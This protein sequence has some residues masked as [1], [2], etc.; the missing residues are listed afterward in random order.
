MSRN[1]QS[2]GGDAIVRARYQLVMRG[3][4]LIVLGY[5]V[6]PMSGSIEIVLISIGWSYIFLHPVANWKL[7]NIVLAT[8]GLAVASIVVHALTPFVQL[9]KVLLPG[10][11]RFTWMTYFAVGLLAYHLLL[12]SKKRQIVV[13][14][15]G[16]I[17]AIAGIVARQLPSNMEIVDTK[18]LAYKLFIGV[19]DAIPH[20]GG[21]IDLIASNAAS[22]AVIALCVLAFKKDTWVSPLQAMGSM[23]L[24][25]YIAHVLSAGQVLNEAS[26]KQ[27]PVTLIL[28]IV[29]SLVL[30]TLWKEFR[31]RGPLESLMRKFVKTVSMSGRESGRDS[32]QPVEATQPSPQL[33]DAPLADAPS[34]DS[35]A[36]SSTTAKN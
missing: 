16:T 29:L 7:K 5:V 28:T 36:T 18:S 35:G 30:A 25:V 6:M 34:P 3:V 9:P 19:I 17:L 26:V 31:G 8:G 12:E 23:S 15:S 2:R 32:E 14:I 27:H 1:A 10:Y 22:L 20:G 33:A 11:P 4:A 24:T 13:L 21:L